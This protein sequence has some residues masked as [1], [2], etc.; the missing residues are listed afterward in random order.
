MLQLVFKTAKEKGYSYAIGGYSSAYSSSV[1]MK[2]YNGKIIFSN[3]Y[4]TWQNS[5]REK[6]YAGIVPEPHKEYVFIECQ[7]P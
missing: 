6:P 4:E 5:R 2:R 7:I 3:S 1:I